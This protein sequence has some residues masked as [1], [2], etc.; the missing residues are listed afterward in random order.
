MSRKSLH[1]T[2]R[3]AVAAAL[4]LAVAAVATPA[5]AATTHL[6]SLAT[7]GFHS[8]W[9]ADD[10]LLWGTGYNATGALGDGTYVTRFTPV[11]VGTKSD[12][13]QISGGYYT[14]YGIR[15]DGSLWS[16][17]YN[18]NGQ[19]GIG[20]KPTKTSTP[21]R[22]ASPWEFKQVAAG[23]FHVVAIRKDGTLWAW[24]ENENGELGIGSTTDHN[25][26]VRVGSAKD[27]VEVTCS[28]RH[29]IAKRAD[30]SWWIWGDNADGQLGFADLKD[31]RSP[32][33]VASPGMAGNMW[34]GG[35]TSFSSYPAGNSKAGRLLSW[36]R[37]QWGMLGRGTSD[38]DNHPV[39]VPADVAST[40]AFA[41][42]GPGYFHT[43]ALLPTMQV[44]AWGRN[45]EGQIG[46][47]GYAESVPAPV[48][49]PGT[50][51]M[52]RVAA[53]E[54]FSLATHIRGEVWGWGTNA[55]GQLGL[56]ALS[57]PSPVFIASTRTAYLKK[58]SAPSRV[59]RGAKMTVSGVMLPSHTATVA[60]EF[61]RQGTS[62]STLVKTAVVKVTKT[63]TG[64][65]WSYAYRPQTIGDWYVK[66][67][68]KDT[69]H[70]LSTSPNRSFTVY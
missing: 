17:G 6:H 24:G 41:Q 54:N 50:N 32:T 27:W 42:L 1:L 63:S 55:N 56:N 53:G 60:V 43:L 16:W 13:R 38:P 33:L 20:S 46:N 29:T 4:L 49:V 2:V 58:P 69:A 8:M 11:V 39:P 61:W 9:I 34:A 35:F 51:G 70:V 68:H 67:T 66:A 30:G 22:V 31:R 18:G 40:L 5:G 26:P 47:G 14:S 3:S 52:T 44:Y 28:A 48:A 10:G 23:V 36:G 19:L 12:W 59:V 62:S 21:H 45:L 15:A 25:K 7:G 64:A 37:N 57:C 65:K